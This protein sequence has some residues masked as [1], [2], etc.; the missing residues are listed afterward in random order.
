MLE[1]EQTQTDEKSIV[2][3]TLILISRNSVSHPLTPSNH[4]NKNHEVLVMIF[5][6]GQ[7][8]KRV[9]SGKEDCKM[10]TV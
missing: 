8:Y 1:G 3:F 10:K 7:S 4:T 9:A 5:V 6:P 2:H